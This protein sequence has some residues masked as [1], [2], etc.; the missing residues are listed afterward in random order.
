MKYKVAF[1]CVHNSCR[2]QMA[3][4]WAKELANEVFDVYSAGTENYSEV[5]PKAVQVMEEVG[6]D[7]S[8][9]KPKLLCDIPNDIDILIKMGCNVT[10]PYLP[11]KHT[12]DWGLDD[13]S[14]GGLEDFRNTRDLIKIKVEE[15]V[16]R[17]VDGELSL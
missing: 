15:L 12:E 3:E 8:S 14:G 11:N 2:S 16:K 6:V 1:V 4:G 7:M 5:K 17:V 10:C 13:P 9:H